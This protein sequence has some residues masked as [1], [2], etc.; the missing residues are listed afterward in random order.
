[1]VLAGL[2]AFLAGAAHGASQPKRVAFSVTLSATVTKDWNT[3]AESTEN[4]CPTS[5][6]SVGKRTVTLRSARPTIVL[7]TLGGGR[8]SYSPAI[9]RNV[10]AGLTQSGS[11]TKTVGTPCLAQ[12]THSRC[13]HQRR[14]LSGA[15]FGFFRSARNEISFHSARLPE[16]TMPCPRESSTVRAIRASLQQAQ[17]ELS[18]SALMDPRT[19]NQTA[20]ASADIETD[21]DAQEKGRVVEH[22]QWALT[23]ARKR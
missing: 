23:F 7:V 16:L 10:N 19:P 9:V 20:V 3:V 6:R 4:G 13:G 15:R 12:M 8:V 11:T 18:E 22:V 14:A 2:L 21:L 1:M 17:G 5:V